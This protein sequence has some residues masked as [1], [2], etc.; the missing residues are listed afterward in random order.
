M[1]NLSVRP[2]KRKH[3]DAKIV[4]FS[5]SGIYHKVKKVHFWGGMAQWGCKIVQNQ[6]AKLYNNPQGF[7]PV[8][9]SLVYKIPL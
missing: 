7:L 8:T 1:S 2:M 5:I 6:V 4:I 9:V 3:A